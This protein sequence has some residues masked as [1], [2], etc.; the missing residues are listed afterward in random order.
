[1]T[2]HASQAVA[3]CLP[4]VL[5]MS[6]PPNQQVGMTKAPAGRLRLSSTIRVPSYPFAHWQEAKVLQCTSHSTGGGCS[7]LPGPL[8]RMIYLIM[9]SLQSGALGRQ[10]S[11]IEQPSRYLLCRLSRFC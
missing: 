6:P 5:H 1:M 7:E 4:A 8:E 9:M 3:F 2:A 10:D 11:N